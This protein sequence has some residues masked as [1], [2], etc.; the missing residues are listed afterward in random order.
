MTLFCNSKVFGNGISK[1]LYLSIASK[2][3]QDS[4]FTIK[5]KD[6]VELEFDPKK[7]ILYVRKK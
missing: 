7:K 6:T 2:M 3:A 5:E 1:T 4:N